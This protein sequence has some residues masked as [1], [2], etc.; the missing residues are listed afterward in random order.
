METE[1]IKEIEEQ[2]YSYLELCAHKDKK[3]SVLGFAKY[4]TES[5]E[6]MG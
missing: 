3:P 6:E 2:Q 5:Y 1:F 4:L